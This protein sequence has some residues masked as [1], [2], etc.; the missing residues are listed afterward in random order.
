MVRREGLLGLLWMV[1]LALL[2]MSACGK[3]G[4][5]TSPTA[6]EPM[7]TIA[8]LGDSLAVSPSPEAN[9]PAVIQRRLATQGHTWRVLNFSRNGATTVEGVA[10]LDEVFAEQPDILV[11]ALGAN[12]GVRGVPVETVRAHLDAIITRAMTRGIRV[13]MCG[14]E[15]PP[16]EGWRYSLAFRAIFPDL[17]RQYDLP[18]VPFLL[19][20]VVG[21]PDMNLEDW[22]HPNALGAERIADT[23]WV[24]LEPM[25]ARAGPQPVWR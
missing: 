16:F 10:R 6:A 9:F 4:T 3:S 23:V 8:V 18:L 17:A 19:T 20:G 11:V 13:L 22:V 15:A 25:I 24:F 2:S 14:M 12:D 7:R 1:P 21:R 5:V